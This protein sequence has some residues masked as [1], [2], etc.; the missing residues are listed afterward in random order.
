[1]TKSKKT[2]SC[3]LA[4]LTL[5]AVISASACGGDTDTAA[6]DTAATTAAARTKAFPHQGNAVNLR[7]WRLQE[8]C[9]AGA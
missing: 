5:A 8:A 4:L 2:A 3:L 9:R 1:M 6:A 7:S